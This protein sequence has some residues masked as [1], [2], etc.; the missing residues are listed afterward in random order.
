MA[1]MEDLFVHGDFQSFIRLRN[2]SHKAVRPFDGAESALITLV[3][4]LRGRVVSSQQKLYAS[5]TQG[6]GKC[7]TRVRLGAK[8][9][10]SVRS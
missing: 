8:V 5:K 3:Q 4:V 6:Q 10:H 9:R 2:I 7:S 1:T